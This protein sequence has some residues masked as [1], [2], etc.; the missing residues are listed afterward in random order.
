MKNPSLLDASLIAPCGMNCAICH[1][2][3]REKN[4]CVGCRNDDVDKSAYCRS[5]II[6]NCEHIE[7]SESKFCYECEK[8]P[9]KRLKQLD[10]RYRDKYHMSMLENLEYIKNKGIDKFLKNEKKRWTCRNCGSIICVHRDKCLECG[11]GWV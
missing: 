2:Y 10:K 7:N 3:L 1:G 4:T 8:L 5:C 11:A 6:K 9:C